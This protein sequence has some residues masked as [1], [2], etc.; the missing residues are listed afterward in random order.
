MTEAKNPFL[1]PYG[2]L[3]DATPF[4]RILT[5]HFEPAMREGMRQE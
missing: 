3:H 5:E 2:T 4:D 1:M